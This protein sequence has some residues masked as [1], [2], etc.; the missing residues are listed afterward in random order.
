MPNADTPIGAFGMAGLA[1]MQ[2]YKCPKCGAEGVE[3]IGACRVCLQSVCVHCGSKQVTL[4]GP[5]VIHTTCFEKN[6]EVVWSS[7]KLFK[8][9][10]PAPDA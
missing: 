1:V 2:K 6:P 7:F 10:K 8:F 5:L 4:T 9:K 3:P